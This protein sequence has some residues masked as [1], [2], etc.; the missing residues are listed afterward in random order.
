MTAGNSFRRS[1]RSASHLNRAA[2]RM[3]ASDGKLKTIPASVSIPGVSAKVVARPGSDGEIVALAITIS[4]AL[5]V[6][7][8]ISSVLPWP[9]QRRR[10]VLPSCRLRNHGDTTAVAYHWRQRRGHQRPRADGA[11]PLRTYGTARQE[12][13]RAPSVHRHPSW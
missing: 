7:F 8:S 12:R 9:C 13:L 6:E 11:A 1:I 4:S 10:R 2:V 5:G 3:I